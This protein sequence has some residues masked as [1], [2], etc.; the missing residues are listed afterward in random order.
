M[1]STKLEATDESTA[2]GPCPLA[3]TI[4]VGIP[5]EGVD[6]RTFLSRAMMSAAMLALAACA[7]AD[8]LSPFSGKATVHISDY[9]ALATVGG[10]ALATLNGSLV[11]LVRDTP[12]SV[13]ALSRVCPHAGGTI[14]TST[15]GFTCPRHGARFS[16]TGTW[17]GGQRTSNMALVH[18]D[19]RRNERRDHRRLNTEDAHR[20]LQAPPVI[21]R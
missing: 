18:D 1:S 20:A 19:V 8:S 5:V 15:G 4:D 11:A 7:G 9:P 3:P 10:V 12:T 14:D 21:V 6:R 13:V 16:L 17:L 2:C